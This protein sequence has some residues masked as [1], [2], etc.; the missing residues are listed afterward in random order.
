[1]KNYTCITISGKEYLELL[2]EWK[3]GQKIETYNEILEI[4]KCMFSRCENID[5]AV[6][7]FHHASINIWPD[8]PPPVLV[9]GD[10][11]KMTYKE[12]KNENKD[13]TPLC[14]L[15]FDRLDELIGKQNL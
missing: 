14:P 2:E 5:E 7:I 10:Q 4:I 9:V 8:K 6:E 15:L 12:F 13:K 3:T 1:M 11:E